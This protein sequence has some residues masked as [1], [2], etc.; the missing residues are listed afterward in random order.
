[1]SAGRARLHLIHRPGNRR[2]AAKLARD[3]RARGRDVWF[4]Q[5]D[6]L[7]ALASWDA[8]LERVEDDVW[9]GLLV[10]DAEL[11]NPGAW[12]I[13][14]PGDELA[15]EM[16]RRQIRRIPIL[17]APCNLPPSLEA[18]SPVMLE[19][20]YD[21]GL[22]VLTDRLEATMPVTEPALASRSEGADARTRAYL[23]DLLRQCRGDITQAARVAGMADADFH[24][25]IRRA[26]VDPL[27]FR[28]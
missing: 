9:L 26:G 4:A 14:E 18:L 19:G 22:T 2:L 28:S 10:G 27:K 20:D 17:T 15:L 7:D 12:L 13:S 24:E 6:V 1:M 25:A 21:A 23:E 3:L 16:A 11:E 5:W 8:L